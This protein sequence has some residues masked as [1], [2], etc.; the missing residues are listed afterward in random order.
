MLQYWEQ[1]EPSLESMM[2]SADAEELDRLEKE[3]ILSYL[4]PIQGRDV[5]ELGS[6]IGYR[7]LA[8]FRSPNRC[9][10]QKT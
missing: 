2:L 8:F 5:L 3:E 1:Y 7:R 6:G 9:S 10:H 4:P